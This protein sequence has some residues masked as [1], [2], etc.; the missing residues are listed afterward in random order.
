MD[1]GTPSLFLTLTLPHLDGLEVVLH[2]H[3]EGGGALLIHKDAALR[4][5]LIAIP[6]LGKVGLCHQLVVLLKLQVFISNLRQYIEYQEILNL[7]TLTNSGSTL[8]PGGLE[9]SKAKVM[10]LT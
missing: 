7:S 6:A 1:G 5:G 8:E 3:G 9:G 10:P 2:S 4:E